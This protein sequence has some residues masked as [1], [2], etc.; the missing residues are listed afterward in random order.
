MQR[1][2]EILNQL[3]MQETHV[4]KTRFVSLMSELMNI[5]RP[6]GVDADEYEPYIKVIK[7][8]LGEGYGSYVEDFA[9]MSIK[10]RALRLDGALEDYRL[11]YEVVG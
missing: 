9:S 10:E 8:S 2:A 3:L 6:K 5:T 7:A 4:S 1:V 11:G